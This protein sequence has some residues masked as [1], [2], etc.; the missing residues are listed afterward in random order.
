MFQIHLPQLKKYQNISG[1]AGIT[2]FL[3]GA[4]ISGIGIL[5]FGW[6]CPFGY[7]LFQT[8]AFSLLIGIISAFVLGNLVAFLL[9]RFVKYRHGTRKTSQREGDFDGN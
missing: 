3:F 2:G 9:I 6:H 4:V 1:I 8:I 5:I 7:G